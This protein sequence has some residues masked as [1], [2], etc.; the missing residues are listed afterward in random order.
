M[1]VSKKVIPL[2]VRNIGDSCHMNAILTS[3]ATSESFRLYVR[4]VTVTCG[5]FAAV[6]N[7]VL[8]KMDGDQS[9]KRMVEP[10][11]LASA[12]R[13]AGYR[14]D[15]P[16]DADETYDKILSLLTDQMKK[17]EASQRAESLDLRSLRNGR[18]T[19][20]NSRRS[21]ISPCTGYLG[22][23]LTCLVCGY[24]E[25][26]KLETFNRL[27][28]A[29]PPKE[30]DEIQLTKCLHEVTGKEELIDG[31]Y[32]WMCES[33]T[34]QTLSYSIARLPQMLC[35]HLKRLN[36]ST[37]TGAPVRDDRPAV[38][39]LKITASQLTKEHGAAEQNGV[40]YRLRSVVLHSEHTGGS[41]GH[42]TCLRY[43]GRHVE[44]GIVSLVQDGVDNESGV[45]Y[46]VNDDTV[47]QSGLLEGERVQSAYMLF[48]EAVS[49]TN[50][51]SF[52]L[53]ET[54]GA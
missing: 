5:G 27:S 31:I 15:L 54:V 42:Y 26:L 53:R 38:I 7:T 17:A 43:A 35:V 36:W 39:D 41:G 18:G 34:P 22:R 37:E 8:R 3:L 20:L 33:S 29:M 45:W 32:C 44:K 24:S 50:Y 4:V 46:C 23:R 16:R 48:Y 1:T 10:Y 12:L 14:V 11:D 28:F 47:T 30:F 6:L 9:G 2:G 52:V 49:D 40:E 19:A 13:L 21:Q 25:G 51:G